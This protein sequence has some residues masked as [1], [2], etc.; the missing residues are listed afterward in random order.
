MFWNDSIEQF[1]DSS[2]AIKRV[3]MGVDQAGEHKFVSGDGFGVGSGRDGHDYSKHTSIFSNNNLEMQWK[4]RR[5][6]WLY[7]VLK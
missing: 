6:I 2:F 7:R 5:I 3:N 4:W 1:F